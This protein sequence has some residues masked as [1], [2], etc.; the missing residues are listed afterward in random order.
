MERDCA[1]FYDNWAEEQMT[2]DERTRVLR[3]KAR[4]LLDLCRSAHL[5]L[6]G[7]VLE[8]GCAEGLLLDE[9]QKAFPQARY[10]GVDISETFIERGREMF[11]KIELRCQDCRRF[12]LEKPHVGFVVISDLLEHLPDDEEFLAAV[13]P[14]CDYILLKIPIQLCLYDS[15]RWVRALR[16]AVGKTRTLPPFGPDHPDGHLRGY[17]VGSARALLRRH[18]L[19]LL[20]E[21]VKAAHHFYERSKVLD[22]V[23]CINERLCVVLFGG[24]YFAVTATPGGTAA[25][26]QSER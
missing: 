22:V 1:D 19:C 12:F 9:F 16:K 18:G 24:A 10:Y 14:H 11:P 2:R 6:R 17:S 20:A 4:N 13:I 7:D 26:V 23:K 8:V 3:W 25:V 15:S 21:Q 5:P